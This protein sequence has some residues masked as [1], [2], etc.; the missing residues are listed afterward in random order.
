MGQK[1]FLKGHMDNDCETVKLSYWIIIREN[2]ESV[3]KH[4]RLKFEM[5]IEASDGEY[6]TKRRAKI[7]SSQKAS[8]IYRN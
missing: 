1:C 4:G 5:Y 7:R 3:A 8:P 6:H 2:L